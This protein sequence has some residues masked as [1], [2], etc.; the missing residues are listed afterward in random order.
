M[1]DNV[2]FVNP[3]QENTEQVNAPS[4][5][6]ELDYLKSIDKT[7]QD[8]IKTVKSVSQSEARDTTPRRDD[9]RQKQNRNAPYNQ[10]RQSFASA[11]DEF[12]SAFQKGMLEGVL[13]SNFKKQIHDSLNEMADMVGME[14]KDI[15]E[16]VGQELGKQVSDALKNSKLGQDITNKINKAKDEAM[17]GFKD[18]FAKGVD[19]YWSKKGVTRDQ[20]VAAVRAQESAKKRASDVASGSATSAKDA[21]SGVV[22]DV[23]SDAAG[24]VVSNLVSMSSGVSG[25]GATISGLVSAA[26]PLLKVIP[27]VALVFTAL[28]IGSALLDAAFD[29]LTPAIEGTK[30]LFETFGKI[31]NRQQASRQKAIEEAN[32]RIQADIETIV[33]RPFDIL[34]EAADKVY[35]AWDA[36]L[37]MINQTQG[38][39]KS[40]LQDL[41]GSYANRLREDGLSSVVS[42]TDI[43]DSLTKVLEAGLSGAAAE[44]FAYIATILNAAIPTQDFFGYADTYASLAANAMKSGMSQA[45]AIDYANEQL[46][47]FA[48]DVLYASREL[49]GGFTTGL[50]DAG[51]LFEDAVKIAQT[52]RTGNPSEIA[53][54]LTAVSA[55][56]GSIAPDLASALT[57]AVVEAAT[58][59]N[60]SQ[61]VALRSLA[62]INASNTEFLQQLAKDPQGI[63]AELFRGLAEMQNM[64]NDAYMEVAEGLSDIFGLSMDAFARVDFN[65][66][67]DAISNMDTSNA[68]L[69]ENLQ[70]LMSGQSTTSA[71]AQRMQQ[72]NEYLIDEGLSYVMDNEVARAIQE[73]MWDEQLAKEIQET[74][75][76]V[77]LQGSALTFLE[78]IRS[79]IENILNFLNPIKWLSKV[80]GNVINTGAELDAMH[81]D[82]KEILEL[83]KVGSGNPQDFYNLTTYGKDLN[84]TDSLVAIMGGVSKY[85][86]AAANTQNWYKYGLGTGLVSGLL[87]DYLLGGLAAGT[88]MNRP[89][90]N[91]QR[92][93]SMYSW[94]TVSKSTAS[95]V[96]ALTGSGAT[97]SSTAALT[98]AVATI[99]DSSQSAITNLDSRLQKYLDSE[100]IQDLVNEGKGYS[101]WYDTVSRSVNVSAAG[102]SDLNEALSELGYSTENIKSVF[103]S[104]ETQSGMQKQ[105]ERYA[106]EEL[107]WDNM[108]TKT[109]TLIDLVTHTNEFLNGIYKVEQDF[110]DEWVDYF[111]N[112]TAY[113]EAFTTRDEVTKIQ[114]QEKSGTEDAIYAL[115]EALQSNSID[116]LRDPTLQTNALLGQILIVV[117]AI[118]QQNNTTSGGLSLPDTLQGLSMGLVSSE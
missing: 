1:A 116:L 109:D 60:S 113:N 6:P 84:L 101:D 81:E 24:D 75:F 19:S 34:E 38:Y 17:S 49:S 36:N 65:Y 37:R 72:I 70:L 39:T 64:S 111:V 2:N 43:T 80:V 92:P 54:V 53:G 99:Q 50:K 27:Q 21:A 108:E 63:F 52:S 73:H 79:T 118:M 106:R 16:A 48:S 87:G 55:A 86:Q 82:L 88:Q 32:K 93:T 35:Q 115:A 13:G 28:S 7:L 103:Q 10:G 22:G 98:S 56:T 107:F 57:D 66:L 62:G 71:E 3:D 85:Q 42:A 104:A 51:S 68:S 29:T 94:G 83:G 23:V 76:A 14:L 45:D 11:T 100:Y 9:F 26:G 15:P 74:T 8:L 105:A 112:H 46:E 110:F 90:S 47:L 30:Q 89:A 5:N 40:D 4:S 97:T 59:G 58:G 117:N 78:G 95:L 33:K 77:E 31:S 41:M 69:A 91:I 102:Y 20:G 61:L 67:A 12:M 18:N 114:N 25:A 44:E 96:S